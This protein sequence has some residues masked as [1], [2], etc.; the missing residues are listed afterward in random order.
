LRPEEPLFFASV[1][2]ILAEV[3]LH[4]NSR[5][6]VDIL[7]LSLE[8]S[9]DLDSTAVDCLIEL[10][11]QLNHQNKVLLLARVKDSI[12][13]LLLKLAAK[14]FHGKLFWSVADAVLDAQKIQ[15]IRPR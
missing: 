15:N 14:Q 5:N 13:R 10:A 8:Q 12:R 9:A 4:L 7:I 2:G 11:D 3:Q 1:E 6:D